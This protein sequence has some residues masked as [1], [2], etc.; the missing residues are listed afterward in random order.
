MR[1]A[2]SDVFARVFDP[3]K[4]SWSEEIQVTKD[5]GG[6]WEPRVTFAGTD[7]W[8]LYDSSRGNE[9]N[10]YATKITA[11]LSVGGT[12]KLIATDRYEGRVSAISSKDGKTIWLACDRGNQQWGLDMRAH[13]GIQG[14][15]GRK[16]TVF[17]SWEIG[18]GAVTEL[19]S[20]DLLFADLP[21]PPPMAARQPARGNNAKAK[22]KAAANNNAKNQQAKK[23]GQ[24]ATSERSRSGKSA[25]SDAGRRRTPMDDGALFQSLLLAG[26][27]HALRLCHAAVDKAIR[28][29]VQRLHPRP[30]DHARHGERRRPVDRL[31]R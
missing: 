3:A 22:E 20:P 31:A 15:N 4:G 25:P 16:D 17:A 26:C 7:A 14:L 10:I 2:L 19:P 23:E 11:D 27:P 28:T 5:A 30:P 21:G 12:K 1:G 13:G 24:P 29:A 18:T 9:F 6:D 8:V